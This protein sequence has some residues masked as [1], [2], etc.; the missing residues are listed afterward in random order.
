VTKATGVGRGGRRPGAG[1]PYK[2]P[3]PDLL[4]ALA[5]IKDMLEA[6]NVQLTHLRQQRRDAGEAVPTLQ[7]RVTELERRIGITEEPK[8]PRLTRRRPLG[9]E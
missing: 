3:H 2:P 7:R 5:A 8:T 6:Q 9:A 4:R 1:R